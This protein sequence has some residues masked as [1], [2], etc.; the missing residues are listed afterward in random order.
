MSTRLFS[1]DDFTALGCAH[2]L[3]E[4]LALELTGDEPAAHRIRIAELAAHIALVQRT[5]PL[6]VRTSTTRP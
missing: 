3:L 4:D 6:P 2:T 5:P 1:P